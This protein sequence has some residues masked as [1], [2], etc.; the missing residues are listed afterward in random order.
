VAAWA[1]NETSGVAVS[2]AS[3]NSN[4]G[5][6]G[7]GV[8]RTAQGRFGGALAFNGSG[9][10]TVPH[11]ASLHLTSGMTLEAWV[12]PTSTPTQWSTVIMKEGSGTFAYTLYAGSPSNRP[13][14]YFN[15]STSQS[16]EHGVAGP[17]ALPLNTWSHLAT[18]YDGSALRLYVNG[19]QVASAA[20]TGSIVTTTG[21]FRFGG[22]MIW[23]EFFQGFIDEVR[24]YNRALAPAEIQA[25]MNT[26]VGN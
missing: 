17:S 19:V 2:D 21:A 16:T 11:S 3:G 10:V 8:T 23:G 5:T 26:P 22:N 15:T 20:F 1:F 12:L 4:T 24:I 13:N 6:L 25:D 7:S 18:T 9:M 14:G